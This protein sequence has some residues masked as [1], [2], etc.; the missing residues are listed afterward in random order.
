MIVKGQKYGETTDVVIAVMGTGDVHMIG[1]EKDENGS[2][3]LAFRTM[4]EPQPINV[5]SDIDKGLEF[6]DLKPQIVFI[7][8]KVESIDSLIN[9]L[10]DCKDTMIS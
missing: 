9:M 8:N 2:V 3:H 10:K 4:E 5:I 7:F 6:D 1:S